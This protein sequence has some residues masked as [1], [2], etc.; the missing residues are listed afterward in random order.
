MGEWP[1]ATHTR[2]LSAYLRSL[3]AHPWEERAVRYAARGA[4]T[5]YD[6]DFICT[7]TT[8]PTN[9]C[10]RKFSRAIQNG[11]LPPH[12]VARANRAVAEAN[13]LMGATAAENPNV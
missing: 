2:P 11:A 7:P 9:K 13:R 12:L 5:I 4:R 8:L 10:L 6:D 3:E 1:P